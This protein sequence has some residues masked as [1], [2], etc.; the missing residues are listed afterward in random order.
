MFDIH[1]NIKRLCEERDTTIGAVCEA[2][3]ISKSTLS[4]LKYGRSATIS[5]STA[6]KIATYLNVPVDSVLHGQKEKPTNDG[7]LAE[8]LEDLRERPET[9]AL[10][11]AS[12]GMS[13]RQVEKMAEFAKTLRGGDNDS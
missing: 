2:V 3:G 11:Q 1:E 12:R 9:R 6:E 13:K 5:R 7:E 4:N 10:L 8:Y